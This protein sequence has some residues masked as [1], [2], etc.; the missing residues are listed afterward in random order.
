MAG[1]E[2]FE[3]TRI[4]DKE[5][6]IMS[7]NSTLRDSH[8]III[9]STCPRYDV[10]YSYLELILIFKFCCIN[11][12]GSRNGQAKLTFIPSSVLQLHH[13][14]EKVELLAKLLSLL[15][16]PLLLV[17]LP[18]PLSNR[19]KQCDIGSGSLKLR[20]PFNILFIALSTH[21]L[22]SCCCPACF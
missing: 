16:P 5:E 11:V 6:P 3:D 7:S 9:V 18:L 12:N 17:A 15:P 22:K 2:N 13:T 10:C 19:L 1:T 14:L 21:V 8:V 4:S 20:S